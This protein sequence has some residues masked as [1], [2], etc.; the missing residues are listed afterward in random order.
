MGDMTSYVQSYRLIPKVENE[1]L[2][3]HFRITY[4]DE[5]KLSFS[6]PF[7]FHHV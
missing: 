3:S 1:K 5:E 2:L 7:G 6:F 4:V